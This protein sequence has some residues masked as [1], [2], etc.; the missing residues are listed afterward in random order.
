L[1]RGSGFV[2]S[3][4]VGYPRPILIESKTGLDLMMVV[5]EYGIDDDVGQNAPQYFVLWLTQMQNDRPNTD[6]DRVS[7]VFLPLSVK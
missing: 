1:L 5:P 7:S 6:I 2:E 4:S 3:L